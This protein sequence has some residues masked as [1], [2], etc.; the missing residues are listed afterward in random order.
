MEATTHLGI[1]DAI[2]RYIGSGFLGAAF[3]EYSR[4][5]ELAGNRT[6][7]WDVA[8]RILIRILFSIL[9]IPWCGAAFLR[10]IHPLTDR[11]RAEGYWTQ[12]HP[13]HSSNAIYRK[14]TVV[15]SQFAA[16]AASNGRSKS[17]EQVGSLFMC[18]PS[19]YRVCSCCRQAVAAG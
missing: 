11:E 7:P 4:S 15:E 19:I 13:T 12:A 1:V 3:A 2:L 14:P 8:S 5:N 17:H 9:R 18:V 6:H 10:A 16:G